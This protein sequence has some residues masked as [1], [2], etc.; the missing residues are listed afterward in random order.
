M[1]LF[2]RFR[3]WILA[4]GLL[5]LALACGESGGPAPAPSNADSSALQ[6]SAP[7]S[8]A[9][10]E[11]AH[12]EGDWLVERLPAEP[13]HLNPLT[14]SD[15]Y[16]SSV[17]LHIF[18]GLLYRDPETL[19]M[20]PNVAESVEESDDH[21]TY[22]FHLRK[23]VVFSDGE[24][25]TAG[26]VKFTFDKVMD[27][28]VDAPHLRNYFNSVASCEVADEYTVRFTCTKPYYRHLVMIGS[29]EIIPEHIYGT[30]DFN[31]HPNNRQPVGSGRYRLDSWKTNEEIVLVR[32][33]KYWGKDTG[34]WPWFDRRIFKII[35]DSTVAL[36]VLRQGG[37]DADTLRAEDWVGPASQPD[38]EEKF[39][40]YEYYAPRYTY[41]GW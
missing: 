34:R 7:V 29:L 24:P 4:L 36:Q 39:N 2:R 33:E 20:K 12:V 9:A 37:I 40:K 18:D 5:P 30:G 11:E 6:A 27:P 35:P 8:Q 41:L 17:M 23:D 10:P 31:S 38:F 14:S 15:A 1:L 25:L 3:C 16:A 26:D 13:P 32:N 21:L 28:L 19:E 22:T